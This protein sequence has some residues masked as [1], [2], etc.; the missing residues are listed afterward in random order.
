MTTP[1]PM[2]PEQRADISRKGGVAAHAAG[3]AHE[4]TAEE[5]RSAGKKGGLATHARRGPKP[6]A[7][8]R[9]GDIFEH[10]TPVD[11]VVPGVTPEG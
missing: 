6:S 2:T 3:T 9:T 11:P 5:A 1:K 7:A 8:D 10:F 4:F